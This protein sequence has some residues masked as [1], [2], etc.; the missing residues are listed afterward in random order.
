M[1]K[2]IIA[3][4]NDIFSDRRVAR[5][6]A[7][8]LSKGCDVLWIGRQTKNSPAFQS[9]F[10]TRRYRML[11]QRSFLFYSFFNI[12]LFFD[13]LFRS[14]DLAV[15]NDLDTLPACH[16]ACRLR[17]NKLLFDSHELFPE[18]P[19]LAHRPRIKKIWERLEKKYVRKQKLAVTVCE[20]IAAYY[21]AKY[22]VEFT[23]IRN[24]PEKTK[25]ESLTDKKNQRTSPVFIYQGALN[26]GRGIEL[27]IRA[28]HFLPEGKLLVVGTGDLDAELRK[29][30]SEEGL[31]DRVTFTGRVKPDKLVEYTSGAT[32]GFS[33]EENLGLNYYYALPNKLFDYIHAQVPVLVS[34]FPEMSR[35]VDTYGVGCHTLEREP[36]KLAAVI[37]SMIRSADYPIWVENCSKAA[38]ELCWEK[39]VLKLEELYSE[40]IGW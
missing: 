32:L 10:K 15:S 20:S 11:F 3:T 22:G 30:A 27:M 23:V 21:H 2:V 7:F 37:R 40:K 33:L 12:R 13:L 29:L 1:K 17:G 4:T 24:V 34:S 39:E 5:T 26:K 14:F 6:A 9:A 19:E 36:E 35:T 28:M 16:L 31:T 25:W 38:E 18:V 8:F